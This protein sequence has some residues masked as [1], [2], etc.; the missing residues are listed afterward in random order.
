MN[1]LIEHGISPVIP[2]GHPGGDL[3]TML[4]LVPPNPAK[5]E[6]LKKILTHH[7]T[8]LPH[9]LSIAK[10]MLLINDYIMEGCADRFRGC[11]IVPRQC[12]YNIT[13]DTGWCNKNTFPLP[14]HLAANSKKVSMRKNSKE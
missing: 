14:P 2:E 3:V 11:L 10:A 8:K 6:S 4:L 12:T 9:E 1:I 5:L 7:D 13:K